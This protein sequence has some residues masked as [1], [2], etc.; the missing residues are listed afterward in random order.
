MLPNIGQSLYAGF[1]T[2]PHRTGYRI[3][4]LCGTA[5]TDLRDVVNLAYK[6]VC[7]TLIRIGRDPQQSAAFKHVAVGFIRELL[8]APSSSQSEFDEW[9]DRC[10]RRCLKVTGAATVH[11]GQAQKLVNMALKYLYNEFAHYRG[12]CNHLGY[13]DGNLEWYFH[14][15]IDSQIRDHLAANY[16]FVHP[17]KVA[18]SKW[19]CDHYLAFQTELRE[20]LNPAYKPL[21]IDYLLWNAPNAS[22]SHLI[23]VRGVP[24]PTA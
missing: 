5:V 3:P 2:D 21:E 18:W 9:H 4:S 16:G 19:D 1:K 14:L 20:R 13:P 11:Y 17:R 23:G 7:R 10:C 8:A 6:D 24:D 12:V 15:P 22:I